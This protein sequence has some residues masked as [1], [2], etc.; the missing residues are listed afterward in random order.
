M[1]RVSKRETTKD[2]SQITVI[3]QK[4]LDQGIMEMEVFYSYKNREWTIV[5]GEM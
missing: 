5:G 3:I 4:M 1:Q 2:H